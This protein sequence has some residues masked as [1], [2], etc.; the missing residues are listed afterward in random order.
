MTKIFKKTSAVL[1]AAIITLVSL[2]ITAF[3]ATTPSYTIEGDGSNGTTDATIE[4]ENVNSQYTR[5]SYN[6]IDL[7]V[8][9][10]GTTYSTIEE[11]DITL[12]KTSLASFIVFTI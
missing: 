7:F 9:G 2:C 11:G 12:S 1:T 8:T 6:G 5:V 4:Y 10:S 3:A